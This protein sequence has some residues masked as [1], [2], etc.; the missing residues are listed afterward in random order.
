MVLSTLF[1]C[2]HCIFAV[3]PMLSLI[4]WTILDVFFCLRGTTWNNVL[5]CLLWALIHV[6][7]SPF[8]HRYMFI[9]GLKV[10]SLCY[11]PS[12][13]LNHCPMLLD[14]FGSLL[15][16]KSLTWVSSSDLCFHVNLWIG[17]PVHSLWIEPFWIPVLLIFP[18]APICSR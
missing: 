18:L 12:C 8:M 11:P 7:K 9:A 3:G 2:T 1:S 6:Q 13:I 4:M 16:C 14:R 10:I 15:S 5:L 17:F